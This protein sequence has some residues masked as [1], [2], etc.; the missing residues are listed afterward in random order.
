MFLYFYGLERRALFDAQLDPQHPDVPSIADEVRR[1]VGVYGTNGSFRSYAS[2]FLALLEAS[3]VVTAN[4]VAP[5]ADAFEHTWEVPF[6][7]RVALGRYSAAGQ[8]IPAEWALLWLRTHPEAYLR[9]PASRCTE[10]FDELFRLRY[11]ARFKDG[12]VV[13]PPKVTISLSYNTASAGFRGS[14][15]TS[16]GSI[17]DLARLTGPINKLRDLGSECTDAL[18]SIQPLPRPSRRRRRNARGHCASPGRAPRVPRWSD[19]G[20]PA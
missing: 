13:K 8:P 5:H 9:T 16:V 19:G 2:R 10:E 4:L 11:Q 14:F 18:D 17:P 3:T 20:Q 6:V 7:V 1:L 12:M 15:D